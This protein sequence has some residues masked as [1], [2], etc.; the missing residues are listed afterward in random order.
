[1]FP[2]E[3]SIKARTAEALATIIFERGGYRLARFGIEE[4]FREVKLLSDSDYLRLNLDGRLRA[5]PDFLVSTPSMDVAHQVEVK[6]RSN[7]GQAARDE[8]AMALSRQRE[9]WPQTCVLLLVGKSSNGPNAKFFQ[10]YVRVIDTSVTP[11]EISRKRPDNEFWKSLPQIADIFP[12]VKKSDFEL[13]SVLP[14]LREMTKLNGTPGSAS[15]A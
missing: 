3:R 10:D 9:F 13:D 14:F 2:L 5:L 11:E 6:F 15:T 7:V 12:L 4:L 8:L 1:M